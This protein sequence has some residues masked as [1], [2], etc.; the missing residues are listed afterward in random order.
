MKELPIHPEWMSEEALQTISS[1]YLL[2]GET[3]QGA[4]RRISK[5]AAKWND[6]PDLE[7]DVFDCLWEGFLGAA[8]PVFANFGAKRA[9]PISC[10]SVDISDSVPSIYSHK[11]EVAM[12]SKNGGGVGINFSRLR[13]AG[14]P[15][16]GGGFSTGVP[17]WMQ[18][19]DLTARKVSQG[20]DLRKGSFALYLNADH[21]DMPEVLR[22]KDHT[23]GDPRD[24]LDSNVGA[25]CSDAFMEG[26]ISRRGKNFE[27][28][29]EILNTREMSGSPYILFIDTVNQ[30]RPNCY[31]E[32]GLEVS[33]SNLC[34]TGETLVAVA[35]GRNAVPIKELVG[36]KFPVYSARPRLDNQGRPKK[37]WVPEIQMAK[38]I[39]TGVRAVVEVELEDGSTF[40]CTPDHL[41][42][43]RETTWV[44]AQNSVGVTLEPFTRRV[45]GCGHNEICC[46]T[47]Y[48]KQG[49]MIWEF[50]N[51]EIP[52]DHHVDHIISRGGDQLSNLQLL[53]KE[54]HWAKTSLERMGGNNPIHKVSRE[55]H[56]AYAS[57]A[58]KGK[59]NSRFCG[60]DNF[61]LIALGKQ[62]LE[63]FGN[64]SRKE[65]LIL[66][67]KGYNV[68][69]SFS[70]YRF[71]GDFNL[72]VSYVK[73]EKVYRGEFEMEVEPP[74]NERTESILND[75]ELIRNIRRKGLRVVSVRSIGEESVYDLQVENNHNFY[76]VTKDS[77]E[78]SSGVLVHNCTEITGYTDENHTFVCVLSS[79][80]LAKFDEWVNW[81]SPR[82]GRSVPEVGIHLLEAVTSEFIH[83]AKNE[84]GLGRAVRFAEKSRMLGLGTMGLHT[85]YQKNN[86]PF[87]S[88][89]ARELNIRAHKFVREMA[90]K[91]SRELAER[92][93][94]PDWCVGSGF[95]HSHRIAIAPTRTNSVITGAFS[96]GIEPMESNLYVAKQDKGA[97]LRKNPVLENL[98]VEKGV[99]NSV[100]REIQEN[101]G[102][103]QELDC[104]SAHEKE[105]FRTAREIDQFEIIRQASQR[106]PYVCQAQ[107]VNLFTT[108]ETTDEEIFR[109]HVSAWVNKVPSLYY[110][111]SKSA[112][113]R[114]NYDSSD[115]DVIVITKADCPYCVRLK[116]ALK[117]DGVD[118]TEVDHEVAKREGMWD[119]S[120]KTVPQL[121]LNSQWVGGFEEYQKLSGVAPVT[122]TEELTES[123]SDCV[124]C[125]A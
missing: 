93:G 34:F 73:G 104:L 51:G 99:P 53:S 59:K 75:Q 18:E 20:G 41:L 125:E 110:L 87:K 48:R 102:S 108:S 63:E 45:N 82:T 52:K 109:L 14:A 43:T 121:Y 103:V 27:I 124:A 19:Y 105:V 107:S 76:I 42:A 64:F 65:Y 15:I 54:D 36:E 80:N 3:A 40:K 94:E 122:I 118:Y 33:L 8:S 1:G 119:P 71:G 96:Q 97:F 29:C 123:P 120:W 70:N 11:K 69:S 114:Y 2:P 101:G 84:T 25:I 49:R 16:S 46:E 31:V 7:G 28:F 85:L 5:T 86:L 39:E 37:Q 83:K 81:R 77:E 91:A 12:L 95:R 21:P 90:D 111:R 55:F 56:S 61:E 117:K 74:K 89:G 68:P 23:T 24:W 35:D 47:G 17:S 22:A 44:E 60:I 100:W 6:D 13:P 92:F 4:M 9:Y 106:Q 57:A 50:H 98:L 62:I 26:V 88:E 115:E 79:A 10:Y 72:Y 58:T 67:D 66:R 112:I 78:L 30:Q 113:T 116:S 38:G 32:R